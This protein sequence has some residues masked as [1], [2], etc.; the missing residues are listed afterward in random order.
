[1]IILASMS[2]VS[3]AQ[4]SPLDRAK[5]YYIQNFPLGEAAEWGQQSEGYVVSFYDRETARAIEMEFD[6]K[7]RWQE[8]TMSIATETLSDEILSYVAERFEQSYTTAYIL[9]RKR[10][11]DFYGLVV[12]TPTHI[13]TLLFSKNGELVEQY[14]E[15]LDGG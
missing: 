2:C 12:D 9:M 11:Q 7:G 4:P 5:S 6:S 1:M 14:S 8:T 10:K 15:G 13:H 3:A